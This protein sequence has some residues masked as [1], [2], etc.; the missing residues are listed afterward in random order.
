MLR[1]RASLGYQT[2]AARPPVGSSVGEC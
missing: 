1:P 2:L